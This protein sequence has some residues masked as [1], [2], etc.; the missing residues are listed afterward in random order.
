MA[1]REF[2]DNTFSLFQTF[3]NASG[4]FVKEIGVKAILISNN[5]NPHELED[6]PFV[7]ESEDN[8]SKVLSVFMG[9]EISLESMSTY[10]Q[11]TLDKRLQIARRLPQT[12]KLRVHLV[13]Q[14][15]SSTMMYML[16]VWP[17]DPTFLQGLD[18]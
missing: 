12:L 8:P 13:N 5:P 16:Q 3:G 15:V 6:L 1:K 17:G 18:S 14:F 7:W 2:I 11:E 10:L 9:E 4:L